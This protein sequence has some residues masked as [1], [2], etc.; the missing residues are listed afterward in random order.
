MRRPTAL[1]V[2]PS[3]LT[4]L[5]LPAPANGGTDRVAQSGGASADR[6]APVGRVRPRQPWGIG[7]AGGRSKDEQGWRLRGY[8]SDC[9]AHVAIHS[10]V[11]YTLPTE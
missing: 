4:A 2:A 7:R 11:P 5:P 8:G 1:Q 9:D 10:G 6:G 3:D